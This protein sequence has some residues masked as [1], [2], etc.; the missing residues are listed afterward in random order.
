MNKDYRPRSELLRNLVGI[1]AGIA[2]LGVAAVS[3]C[4]SWNP[5][6]LFHSQQP[7]VEQKIPSLEKQITSTPSQ[8][9]LHSYAKN[10]SLSYRVFGDKGDPIPLPHITPVATPSLYISGADGKQTQ[11]YEYRY[12]L[13]LPLQ[14][15]QGV[16]EIWVSRQGFHPMMEYVSYPPKSP[17]ELSRRITPTVIR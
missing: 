6:T 9:T 17:L 5:K 14:N 2:L 11:T 8:I 3:T 10:L 1:G 7:A 16:V 4:N 13:S 15:Y 12:A